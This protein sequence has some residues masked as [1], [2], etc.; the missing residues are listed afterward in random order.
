MLPGENC[1][2]N[3]R[4]SG[5]P[6]F[7]VSQSQ[8]CEQDNKMSF[9]GESTDSEFWT[10]ECTELLNLAIVLSGYVVVSFFFFI[11]VIHRIPIFVDIFYFVC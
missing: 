6:E 5:I 1:T 9:I 3:M 8:N 2:A 7:G 10:N 4:N 11:F